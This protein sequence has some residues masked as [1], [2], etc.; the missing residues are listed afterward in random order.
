MNNFEGNPSNKDI[1]WQAEKSKEQPSGEL[2]YETS[3]GDKISLQWQMVSPAERKG[4]DAEAIVLLPGVALDARSKP[5]VGSAQKYANVSGLSSYSIST[6]VDNVDSQN[7]DEAQAEA[8]N[9]FVTE[10]GLKEIV[11]VGNSKGADKSYDVIHEIKTN[12][13]ELKIRG[14]I[15]SN[16]GGIIDQDPSE[17]TYNF[18]EDA[19]VNTPKQLLKNKGTVNKIKKAA[20]SASL[21]V[22]VGLGIAK[23]FITAPK[24]F[25]RRVNIESSQAARRNTHTSDVD[26]P[27]IIVASTEDRAFPSSEMIPTDNVGILKLNDA[28]GRGVVSQNMR[29]QA[30]KKVFPNAPAIR[31]LETSKDPHGMHYIHGKVEEASWHMLERVER[32]LEKLK[33]S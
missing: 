22:S 8:I 7:P 14:L 33:K 21:G 16:P 11:I 23:E 28:H 30:M 17:L 20:N 25:G 5:V 24:E 29:E 3:S 13:P 12:N 31:F 6:R 9:K 10:K 32:E 19:F 4:S 2:E 15:P 1:S 26:M 27:V 18:F